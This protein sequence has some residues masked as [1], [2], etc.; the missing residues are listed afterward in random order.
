MC[1][2]PYV[3]SLSSARSVRAGRFMS[4][5]PFRE[6]AGMLTRLREPLTLAAL[7]L[8]VGG[9]ALISAALLTWAR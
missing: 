7:V 2:D 5:H 6:V 4:A 3:L 9:F 8:M 1:P